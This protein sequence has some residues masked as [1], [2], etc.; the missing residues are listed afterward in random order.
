M[1]INVR[2]GPCRVK[3]QYR[4]V[5]KVVFLMQQSAFKLMLFF[6]AM[7]LQIMI[8]LASSPVVQS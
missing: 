2:P 7:K 3:K 1:V 4:V 6:P 8:D 5:H